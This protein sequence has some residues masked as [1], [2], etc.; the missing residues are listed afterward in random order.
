MF[1]KIK[2]SYLINEYN[3]P[4]LIAFLLPFGINYSVFIIIWLLGFLCFN[5]KALSFKNIIQNKWVFVFIAFFIIHVVGYFFSVNKTE[6]LSAIE[7]KL[8]FLIFPILIFSS[9]YN[10]LQLKKIFIS[11]V[12]GCILASS[13]CLFHSF[14][15]YLLTKRTDVFFYSEYNYFMHP[16]YFAMYL[17][18][19]QLIVILFYKKWLSHLLYLNFKIG[20]ITLLNCI[21]IILCSSKM[22]IITALII[23]PTTLIAIMYQKGYKKIIISF[24]IS[25]LFGLMLIYRVFPTPFQRIKVALHVTASA[26]Q[27]NK[28]DSES[29]AVR[30]LI[31]KE[32]VK[33]IKD[34]F[35]M[36][37]TPG[38][39]HDKL[40]QSYQK[41]GL[42][43]AL[44]KK[45]NTHN[46]FLQTFVGTG[47]IGFILLS[48]ITFGMLI[49]SIVK[50][51]YMLLLFSL[52]I[53]FNFLV[54]SMLQAQAG[55]IFY[56]FFLCILLRYPFFEI[57]HNLGT[58]KS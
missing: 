49:F 57:N 41:E 1:N 42:S 38:D 25:F 22:G 13:L 54:E 27:I 16:S 8:S 2:N 36:G 53:I 26:Q 14:Y 3:V 28:T 11:F 4:L 34:N 33:L 43:G 39:A 6:A 12:T 31:W 10:Q 48:L 19:A 7:I 45:L 24:I 9:E 5:N 51:D 21:S 46:Q 44:I 18:F 55:F 37:T 20:F 58:S 35:W 32:A 47:V 15:L 30:I 52:L 29:T 23:F 56:V 17:V 40:I 50:K